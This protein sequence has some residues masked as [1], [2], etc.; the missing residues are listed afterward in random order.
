MDNTR[1]TMRGRVKLREWETQREGEPGRLRR[2]RER[3]ALGEREKRKGKGSEN[4]GKIESRP[5]Y[6]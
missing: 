6:S 5:L 3:E 1:Q 2:E 4:K